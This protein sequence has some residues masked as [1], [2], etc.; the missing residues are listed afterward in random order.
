MDES[1]GGEPTVQVRERMDALLARKIEEQQLRAKRAE[2][3]KFEAMRQELGLPVDSP[4]LRPQEGSS[5]SPGLVSGELTSSERS[6]IEVAT[7]AANARLTEEVYGDTPDAVLVNMINDAKDPVSAEA[8]RDLYDKRRLAPAVSES[9][10]N[11]PAGQREKMPA[12]KLNIQKPFWKRIWSF[13][14]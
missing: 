9:P 2:A 6:A 14:K 10:T 1:G 7:R 13:K 12:A 5:S 4:L 8:L 11:E 3:D